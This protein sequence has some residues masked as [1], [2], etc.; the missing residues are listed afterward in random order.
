MPSEANN[1]LYRLLG[2][3]TDHGVQMTE[4]Q[5]EALVNAP[6]PE[7]EACKIDGSNCGCIRPNDV[8]GERIYNP[9]GVKRLLAQM[10]MTIAVIVGAA[11]VYLSLA[12]QSVALFIIGEA[13]CF[14]V[15]PFILW[16]ERSKIQKWYQERPVLHRNIQSA[17]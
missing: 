12:L 16:S 11:I 6:P 3:G 2:G 5:F 15:A 14:A 17:S 4:E 13:I 8:D 1:A 7:A 10:L 9:L